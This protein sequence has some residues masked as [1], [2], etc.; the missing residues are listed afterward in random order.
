MGLPILINSNRLIKVVHV[1]C[2]LTKTK[3]EKVS[4]NVLQNVIVTFIFLN[5]S[6]TY[7]R[8]KLTGGLF[9]L[10]GVL[11]LLIKCS[12]TWNLQESLYEPL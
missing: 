1:T 11:H 8:K 3:T 12:R 9:K 6:V 7:S 2:H 10:M 5:I 4:I